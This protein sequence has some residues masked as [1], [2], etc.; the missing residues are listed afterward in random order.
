M[1]LLISKIESLAWNV[2][3]VRFSFIN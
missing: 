3:K 2:V 1:F